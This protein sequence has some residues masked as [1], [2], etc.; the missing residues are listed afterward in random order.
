M[1]NLVTK[2]QSNYPGITF[3]EGTTFRWSPSNRC[4]TYLNTGKDTDA[5]SLLHEVSHAV[6]NHEVYQSDIELLQKE[7]AA[8]HTAV[9]LADSYGVTI[10]NDHIEICLDSYR[11]WIHKRSTCPQCAL[12]G[13]QKSPEQYLCLNCSH[14]WVVTSARFCRPYR[15]SK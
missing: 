5:W 12:Q 8:W 7:V 4:V 11:D 9:Q 6:L 15:R 1:K 14:T 3:S 10:D 2:L 13:I